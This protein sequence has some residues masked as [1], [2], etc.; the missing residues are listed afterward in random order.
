MNVAVD[1]TLDVP[2]KMFALFFPAGPFF[3]PPPPHLLS[4]RAKAKLVS[5]MDDLAPLAVGVGDGASPKLGQEL[6]HN[7]G[8]MVGLAETEIQASILYVFTDLLARYFHVLLYY[9]GSFSCCGRVCSLSRCCV[10]ILLLLATTTP[11]VG[12]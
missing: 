1:V 12:P 10:L 6:L 4:V 7:V 9:L 2:T 5:S 11:P 3:S 8:L